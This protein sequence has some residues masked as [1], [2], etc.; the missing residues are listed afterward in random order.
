MFQDEIPIDVVIGQIVSYSILT[1]QTL[2]ILKGPLL[3]YDILL[4]ESKTRDFPRI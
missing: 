4:L 1:Q 2:V 3:E